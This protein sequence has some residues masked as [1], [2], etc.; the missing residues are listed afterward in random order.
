MMSVKAD[1]QYDVVDFNDVPTGEKIACAVAHDTPTPHRIAAVYVFDDDGKL[2][3]QVHKKS[4]GLFDHS[5]GG[6]VDEGETYHEA[7]VREMGEEIGL[8][9]PLESVAESVLED[10]REVGQGNRVHFHGIFKTKAPRGWVFQPNDE[11]NELRLMTIDDIV[12]DMAANP[13]KYTYGFIKTMQAYRAA[14]L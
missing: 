5:V 3:V 1:E 6:H 10:C 7:A 2:Y 13:H 11:V 12:A 9:V 14:S 8:H 4:G